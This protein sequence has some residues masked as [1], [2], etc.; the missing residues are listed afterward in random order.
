MARR[1]Y[2]YR[3]IKNE[4]EQCSYGGVLAPKSISDETLDCKP[5]AELINGCALCDSHTTCLKCIEDTTE[6]I[7][8]L[9][10]GGRDT[11]ICTSSDLCYNPNPDVVLVNDRPKYCTDCTLDGCIACSRGDPGG[12]CYQCKQGYTFTAGTCTPATPPSGTHT[13]TYFVKGFEG[14]TG[15]TSAQNSAAGT[16]LSDPYSYLQQAIYDVYTN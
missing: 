4:G 9:K 5:C 3:R 11:D 1:G 13:L 2:K 10:S 6:N 12:T 15:D 8:T 16:S 14:V 7:I